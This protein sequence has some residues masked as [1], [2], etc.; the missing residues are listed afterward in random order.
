MASP[1]TMER[2]ASIT[3]LSSPPPR[4]SIS[5]PLPPLQNYDVFLSHRA[6]D[7]GR[8]FTAD[9]H[10]ALTD[11]GI[12]VFRDDVDEEDGG[13]PLTEKM[14]AVEE[15]RSSIVVFSEN[16]GNLVCMKEIEKIV[17]CKELRDQLVLPIFYL[18]NPAHVRNQKGNFEKHFI[19]HE[20]NP[21][22][23][24][25]EV[26]SW[27]Y[28]MQQVGHLSGWH[29]QDSQ[30][31]AGTI[32]EVVMHIFNK[33]RP[34]LFRYDDKLV[35]ISSRLHQINMLMGI[36]L[37]D[38]RFVGIWGMGGI[39]K[40]T[41]ARIIYKS[42]SHLFERYYF[43]DNVKEALKKEGL[44]SLQEKLLTGALMKR[45]IDI[46]NADGATLIKRRIS[47]LKVL[48]ILDD[49]DHLSQL[50]KLAGG[51][52]W[53]GSG[54]RVI[55]T[56]RNEHLLI[57]HGIER[58][59]NVEGLK[60]EEAL[61]LFSQ[62][63]FGEDHPK[64]GY[65]DLSSQVVSY[66]GGLP[67]AI[68]VLGSSLRNKPMKDWTNAVEKL[69]E[70]RDKE[71]LEK[72][73]ISYYMLEESEQKIFL[74][75]ACFFKKKSKKQAIE[76]LQ[77]FEFLA[78][79]GLEIL[80][81][82]SLITTPHDKI[83][84]HD[85]IQEMGQRIV[86]ENFPN[87]PEKRS[88]LWLREDINRALSRDKGTEAIGGIMMDM[89]EEGESHLNAKSF[90]AMTNLRVLK[91]NNVYLSEELQ[92]LSDQLRF[93]NWHGYP[94]K[95][96]PSNFN[97][98]NLLELELPNSSI[99][100]L[101]TTSKS[102]ETL[103]VINLSDSQFLSKTPDF[104]G[105]PN[106]ERLVLSGC[107]DIHQLHHS[108]GNLKHLIQLD[109]RNCKKLTTIPFNICLESL[110]ILVL[111]GC[112][113]LTHFP[114]ISGNMN[115]LL[116]L[117]L[118]ETSIKNL[119]SSIGHLTALVLLNLKNCTNLLKLPSTI[120]CLTSLKTLNLNGCSKLDSLPESLGNIFCLEKLDITNTC[121]NQA[122]MSLQLLTKLEIL[123]CQGLSRKFLQSLFPTWNFTRKF[124]HYQG[125]K[126][127]NWFHF[128]CSLRILNLSDCN[129]WDGDLPND[130]RSLASLQILHLSQN[131][132][133]KLPE[134]ISHLVNLRDLFLVECSH[135]LS[136]PKLPLSVRDVEARDCVSLNEYYNQEKQIPSS[137]MGMT[138]IRCPI[139]NEPSES[140]KIDQPRL[141]AIHLR[142]M[143]QRYIE[144]LTWQQEKYFFVIP[145]PSF[146][147]CFDEKR[148]GF[149]ITAHCP[150]DYINEENPRIGIALGASFEVQKHE[151][152]NNN[153]SK[154]CCEFIVKMETDE[155]P[156]KSALVFD[157]NKDELESP[158]GLSVFY[159]PMR[160][161]SGWLNQ[162]CCIDV[163]IMTDNPLV[164]V[165]WCGAS[166]LYEQNAGSFIGKIIK[167]F[168]GSPGRYHTSIVDHILNRQNRVDV[169]TLLDGGAHYKT[170]W[171]NAL[172][173]TIG[174]FPR[175]RPSRPPREVIEDCSTMNASSE[176]DENESDYSIMLKRNIKATLERTFEELKL[177]GE[178]YIFPQKEISRSWFN[179]QLKE[180]K[181]TI[182][183]SPNLH[184]DK[185]WMGLAFFV[186][187]S[188]DENS[189]KSHSFSYQ[190]E[191][192]EYTMQRQSIIY[193][194][195][196]LFDDSHQLWMF[197]EPRAVYPYRLNQWRHLRFAFVCNDSDFKAVLCGARLVYK[198]DVEGFVNTIVSNVLSSPVELHEF[199]DQ[200]YVKGMLRNVQFHKYDPKNKEEETRQDLLIQE[201]EE[202]Q[203]SNAYPQQ[204]ST[205]SPNMERSH[206]LQL[207]ES[208][209]SF[210]QKDSKDRFQNT[211]DFVIPRRN[212]PQLFNQ[213]SP[214]NHTGIEL[215]PNLYTTN[216]WMGFLVC[217]LFQVNKHP[218]AILNN[219]GSIT[220]HELICQF[221]IEN[222]LIEPLHLHSITEDRFIWLHERQFVWLY[223][224]PRNTYGEIFRHRSCIWAIIEADTPDL[225]VRCCGLQLVYKQDMEVIDKILMKA[226]Q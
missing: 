187:F 107:V 120:G 189:P 166:I 108:L 54:S 31:E 202:E 28:S 130:L 66:A 208:I 221:A 94:L 55:V 207:K 214:K 138:F 156:L 173:R 165:K 196:E 25:E 91:V 69:W 11:K 17:M 65:Y 114:K 21:E 88:R 20:A 57:S 201:W 96:L 139:S 7:T 68:E 110:H 51:L 131:H 119:H 47:N 206:I 49:I 37:D 182:K 188:A 159:I 83:Q 22:I 126:V 29:L 145:Y 10:D 97:P 89:D 185:K 59:Y 118:D 92:Y 8:S 192:D 41:I 27:K 141:S 112:S 223:Y 46:P 147:A 58:R 170:T 102:L 225:M 34:D 212:F 9:L 106:L 109:L 33:L 136:L 220:R 39:G 30:S 116:E 16:Y 86:S 115:H 169:S 45:N 50:Q 121:V 163:S 160:R 64:K 204:D 218:T 134:S 62:K 85:L 15:S 93:L 36:G 172:Q 129:L 161:I 124:S 167:A 79:L 5:L 215:P 32:N 193:L 48:I 74:D 219:L 205:S 61:Q 84:M 174:S 150:P 98:T 158:V 197:F 135:L 199:Y 75:I 194:N 198:Q 140:Y 179:F 111:S 211:F 122:P 67:L 144:V 217:T 132:F 70:V 123:N 216:D 178:Y 80:E 155:C 146:I 128:G 200:S 44:A 4:Y 180:P 162:C 133:T 191:N 78:V 184:K 195:E 127:T 153:N 38:V 168:F 149:S 6:K 60:I 76:I 71:I 95:C 164:K 157:G 52:D 13:K 171:F 14:K 175:L 177:Y 176:I 213:L 224:S 12:V 117:H 203:N 210:L 183:I 226:I 81:E 26:K 154:I 2:R 3:S 151:I 19:E 148:Y 125:L 209:P 104:S 186:V 18:I 143:A 56:T 63:A 73:K 105:V 42:V 103:K 40:T 35:G 77:S 99:Q 137:E 82:K 113:N 43:L 190:V 101:W 181:I 23:N 222:G 90:S 72:L 53:F 142:T 1:A 24:I 100:H 152:S 87:E